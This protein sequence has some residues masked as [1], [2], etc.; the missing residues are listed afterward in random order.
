MGILK[1]N[2]FNNCHQFPFFFLS[3]YQLLYNVYNNIIINVIAL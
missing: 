2:I 3:K 1:I